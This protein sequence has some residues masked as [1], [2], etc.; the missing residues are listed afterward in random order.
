MMGIT[1][2]HF[3]QVRLMVKQ[4]DDSPPS[5]VGIAAVDPKYEV[6]KPQSSLG[7]A[8]VQV[9]P[10]GG[11]SQSEMPTASDQRVDPL[12]EILAE[13]RNEQK[14]IR[15]QLAETNRDLAEANFRLD[16]HSDSFKPLN[17][18]VERPRSLDSG[19]SMNG[20]GAR[21]SHELLPPKP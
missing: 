16:T 14:R 2:M 3:Q 21:S 18:D 9:T 12:L 10:S 11:A 7:A 4:A 17:A 19:S 5:S 1:G 8:N 20:G 15:Q 6:I 13:M